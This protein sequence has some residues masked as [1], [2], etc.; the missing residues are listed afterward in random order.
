[1]CQSLDEKKTSSNNE[2]SLTFISLPPL[3]TGFAK[4][5]KSIGIVHNEEFVMHEDSDN[6]VS[7]VHNC[8]VPN[9][10]KLTNQQSK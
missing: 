1:M 5:L 4:T 2:K 7:L 9:D 3:L 8:L 10:W 6:E